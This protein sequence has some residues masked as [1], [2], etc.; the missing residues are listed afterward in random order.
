[1]TRTSV[2]MRNSTRERTGPGSGYGP[3]L[4]HRRVQ[5]QD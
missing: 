2:T 5:D 1:M 3:L 4:E